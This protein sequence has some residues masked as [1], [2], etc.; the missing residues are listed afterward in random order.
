[1]SWK[2]TLF[3]A[4]V[5]VAL[6]SFYYFYDV[7]EGKK[8][9]EAARQRDLLVHITADKVTHF[10]IR[11]PQETLVA[12][13]RHDRWYLTAPLARPG[14]SQKYRELVRYVA[15]LHYTRVVEETPAS[16]EPFG[17]TTPTLEIQLQQHDAASPVIIRLGSSNP[18][19]GSYYAQVA[20]Q[21]TVYLVAA[22]A[23]D[24]LDAS[25]HD[26][27]DKTVL[28][29]TPEEVQELQI[30][31]NN[32]AAIVLQ[33]Q[34]DD[35]WQLTAPIQGKAD[36]AQAGNML[37]R[38]H[39]VRI[40][41]FIADEPDGLTPYGLDTPVARVTLRDASGTLPTLVLGKLE[42]KQQGIYTT[43]DNATSV[44]L[45]PRTFWDELPK[46]VTAW[47][48]KTL[49][50]YDSEHITR[51]DIAAPEGPISVVRTAPE[52]YALE[53]PEEATA[54]AD[55]WV[56]LLWELREIKAKDFV[57]ETLATPADYGLD[58]PRRQI[59]LWESLPG[60]T[61]P[62]VVPHTLRLGAA[63]PEGNGVYVQLA[64][65]PAVYLIDPAEA[66]R[67]FEI[68][69]FT[70]RDKKILKFESETV[71]KIEVQYPQQ[72][73]IVERRGDN[74]WRL[75]APQAR[76][77]TRAWK[78][79]NILYELSTLEYQK[80]IMEK[81]ANGTQYGLDT[82]QAQIT[83]WQQDGATLGPLVVGASSDSEVA[84]TKTVYV[85]LH[86]ETPLYAVAA[87]FLDNLPKTSDDLTANQ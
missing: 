20:D 34:D 39:D 17:L 44:F 36:N 43:Y 23:K 30:A 45:L 15:E 42:T 16:L 84:G 37:Q 32:A 28:A 26:V 3:W 80:I 78:V 18:A 12:E 1:M 70:L 74:T 82:P 55:A 54:D 76:A 56:N 48:D 29:F 22:V 5:L 65:Q 10:T 4:L 53:Q 9:Q 11:R 66:Q 72:R 41:A 71:Q 2:K 73:L 33:R 77:I 67:L 63:T 19:G 27:R 47:R 50:Q 64:D 13:K 69:A 81:A 86:H 35:G 60:T 40:Q 6:V 62:E 68:S 25:L 14:D 75:I 51:L 79:D 52:Q 24:V 46:T 31:L 58:I 38:L 83:L 85:Q 87:T 21:P 59:T 7:P 8:R 57:T 49:L 61:P